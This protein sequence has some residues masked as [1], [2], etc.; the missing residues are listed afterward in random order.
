M[1]STGGGAPGRIWRAWK[2]GMRVGTGPGRRRSSYE[3]EFSDPALDVS[4][5]QGGVAQRAAILYRLWVW[6]GAGPAPESS[7]RRWGGG[8]TGAAA[9][10]V[11]R[12]VSGG[13]G[14]AESGG[15]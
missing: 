12:A 9:E 3:L 1:R 15:G 10:A 2:R 5:L 8:V 7:G 4:A 11:R 13:A 6:D 14:A